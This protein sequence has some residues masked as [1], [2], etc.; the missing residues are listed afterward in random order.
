MTADGDDAL[1]VEQ[2]RRGSADALAELFERYWPVAW[3]TAYALLAS[4]AAADDAAQ[5]GLQRAFAALGRFERGRPFE[6]WLKRI[7]ANRALDELRREGRRPAA[8]A[9][10]AILPR[11]PSADAPA[12]AAAVAALPD[13]KRAVVVLRYWLD[14]SLE[15]IA[16]ELGVP[17]GTASSRLSRALEELRRALGNSD[18]A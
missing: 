1:L 12:L 9:R 11:E 2:A 3:R 16:A 7:V 15:E 18:V 10:A 14:F 8:E 17:V 6:P 5:E 4:R 13:E